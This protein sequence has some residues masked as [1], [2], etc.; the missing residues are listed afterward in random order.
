MIQPLCISQYF[1]FILYISFYSKHPIKSID[2]LE[3]LLEKTEDFSQRVNLFS[4]S[5]FSRS[6]FSNGGII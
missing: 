1:F 6:P 2:N 4:F 5:S 3:N